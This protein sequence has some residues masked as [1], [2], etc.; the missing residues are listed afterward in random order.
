MTTL[1]V[2]GAVVGAVLAFAGLLVTQALMHKRWTAEQEALRTE[3]LDQV[4]EERREAD[5]RLLD[6]IA[7]QNRAMTQNALDLVAEHRK[8]AEELRQER[9][10]ANRMHAECRAEVASLAGRLEELRIRVTETERTAGETNRL[11]ELHRDVKHDALNALS[12]SE[13]TMGLVKRQVEKCSCDAYG[14]VRELVTNYEPKA[15][16]LLKLNQQI[17]AKAI[18]N[19]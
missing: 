11:I 7:E 19:L 14:P 6:Q 8:D 3:A 9:A 5:R 18:S 15:D 10:E 1:Q 12:V 16:A 2:I 17:T 4:A 13:G